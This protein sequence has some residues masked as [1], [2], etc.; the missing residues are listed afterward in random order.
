MMKHR[1]SR[2]L[3]FVIFVF[4]AAL[5]FG[6]G[7]MWLWNYLMPGL[8]GLHTI[9]FWQALAI[10][11]LSRILFCGF[12]GRH[13]FGRDWRSRFIWE[14]SPEERETLRDGLR[15]WKDMTPEERDE[16][17]T[18]IRGRSCPSAPDAQAPKA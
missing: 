15:H 17:R 12:H 11:V 5:L 3:R 16:F 2:V 1:I 4:L 14:L 13:G 7:V 10:L 8:F 18:A 6:F 9:S